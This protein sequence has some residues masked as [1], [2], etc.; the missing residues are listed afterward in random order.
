MSNALA[1]LGG[2][3]FCASPGPS[4]SIHFGGFFFL[5][6]KD[7][8]NC[9]LSPKGEVSQFIPVLWGGNSRQKGGAETP[10]PGLVSVLLHAVRSGYAAP[11]RYRKFGRF[12]PLCGIKNGINFDRD[13]YFKGIAGF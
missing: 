2:F 3:S 6:Y 8:R 1:V 5:R 7:G 10:V 11:R 9:F 13:R 4:D 12:I